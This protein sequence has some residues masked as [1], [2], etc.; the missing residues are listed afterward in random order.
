[1]LY[2]VVPF[3][4]GGSQLFMIIRSFLFMRA[5][6]QG[7][8]SSSGGGTRTNRLPRWAIACFVGKLFLCFAATTLGMMGTII[9]AVGYET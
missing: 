4:I 6:H 3:V 8:S 7:P 2:A 5:L 1:M 9:T